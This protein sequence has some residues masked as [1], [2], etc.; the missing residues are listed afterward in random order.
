MRGAEPHQ[1]GSPSSRRRRTVERQKCATPRRRCAPLGAPQPPLPTSE[2]PLSKKSAAG[3][4]A[5][6]F[7]GQTERRATPTRGRRRIPCVVHGSTDW[8][9]GPILAKHVPRAPC[10]PQVRLL[11]GPP[12]SSWEQPRARRRRR[13]QAT[14]GSREGWSATRTPPI[15]DPSP[16]RVALRPKTRQRRNEGPARPLQAA[17][18]ARSP[19][20]RPVGAW[21]GSEA[22]APRAA[23]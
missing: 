2:P 12:T 10:M 17:S 15:A 16:H 7:C 8:H 13:R 9:V 5:R 3:C 19:T 14:E 18:P 11:R 23:A 22:E 21:E 20:R 1:P 6:A 4:G